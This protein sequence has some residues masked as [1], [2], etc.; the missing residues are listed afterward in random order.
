M[1]CKQTG[2]L[3][4]K[5]RKEK[6]LKQREV[7]VKLNIS[8][9]TVSKWERG[10]GFPDV[11]LIK[12]L[13]TI[14]N[15]KV[16]VLLNGNMPA[17]KIKN[18]SLNNIKFFVCPKCANI[19]SSFGDMQMYCCDRLINSANAEKVEDEKKLKI[20]N[21]ENELFVHS[22][23]PMTKSDYVT[24]VAYAV[25]NCYTLVKMFPEWNLQTRFVYKGHGKLYFGKN[26]GKI[27]YQ[28][29]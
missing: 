7:A 24:F 23:M 3:I 6:N 18:G 22:D 21:V 8:E 12:Q 20:D 25:G 14:L 17:S 4:A 11:N 26:N 1:D 29:I 5:L 2:M 19:I 16:E 10:L 15:V 9:Q 28:I 27:Y 13:A